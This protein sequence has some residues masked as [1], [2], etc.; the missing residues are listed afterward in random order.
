[1]K[2]LT[3]PWLL[4]TWNSARV[5]PIQKLKLKSKAT[6][7]IYL[8]DCI[9]ISIDQ[10]PYLWDPLLNLGDSLNSDWQISHFLISQEHEC[11]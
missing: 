1:M 9:H 4:E 6:S 3:S 10:P 7:K 11:H 5:K 8:C 2:S